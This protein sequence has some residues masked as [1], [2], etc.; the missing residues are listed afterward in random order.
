[1]QPR[2]PPLHLSA[3]PPFQLEEY[4]QTTTAGKY[5]IKAFNTQTKC[6]AFITIADTTI[7]V[8][9]AVICPESVFFETAFYGSFKESTD[10]TVNLTEDGMA[11]VY[12]LLTFLYAGDYV[13]L[14]LIVDTPS[15]LGNCEG[16][17]ENTDTSSWDIF[18]FHFEM[19]A[20]GDR[21]DIGNLRQAAVR[22][23]EQHWEVSKPSLQVPETWS[24]LDTYFNLMAATNESTRNYIVHYLVE[25]SAQQIWGDEH[26]GV[27][28][29]LRK[30]LANYPDAA[31]NVTMDLFCYNIRRYCSW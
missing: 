6:D 28:K 4:G 21:F 31:L 18:D 26:N 12:W 20:L 15:L 16:P 23:F 10:R 2:P 9:K 24:V 25:Y 13:A 30:I 19:W 7:G 27:L 11:Q 14:D 29:S 17:G 1:M 5:F 3:S 8:H 22:N